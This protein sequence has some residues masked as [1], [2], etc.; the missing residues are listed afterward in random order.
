MKIQSLILSTLS[1]V[2]LSLSAMRGDLEQAYNKLETPYQHEQAVFVDEIGEFHLLKGGQ[3]HA[4]KKEWVDPLLKQIKTQ[5]QKEAFNRACYV[6]AVEM[7]DNN[8]KLIALGRLHGGGLF[9]AAAGFWIGKGAVLA[10]GHGAIAAATVVT[11]FVATP[12][13]AAG[14]AVW[15]E[16]WLA[17]PIEVASNVVGLGCGIGGAAI[18]GPV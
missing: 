2:S 8:Y 4:V 7:S 5:K 18:T 10:A 15:M 14:A 9:G 6:R 16:A 17:G 11:A 1:L 3:H 12:V 13:V